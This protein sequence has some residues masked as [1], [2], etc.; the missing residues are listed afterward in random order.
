MI[1]G[2][3]M[4]M[5]GLPKVPSAERIDL[6]ANGKVVGL[7][8]TGVGR[9]RRP[10]CLRHHGAMP[11]P[12]TLDDLR[13][14]A[15]A[16]TLFTPTTL[17]ARDRAARLRAGR[18]DP[19]A[20][21]R[22]GPD[23]AP[24]R[25]GLPRRRPRA[26]LSRGSPIEEDFFV[27]YGFLPRAHLALMHPRTPRAAWTPATRAPGRATV[28]EFVRERGPAHPREVDAHFAHG[29]RH[30]LTGAARR[31]ATT[32]LL[33][34]M[35]Y[36]G[37]LRV[38]RRDGGTRIYAPPR[39][40]RRRRA[41][42]RAPQRARRAGRRSSCAS[43]R[44][45]RR[46]AWRYLVRLLRLRRAASAPQTQAALR[47]ARERARAARDRR[48]RP[49]T[50][51]PTRTRARAPCARRARCACSRRSIRSSGTGGASSCS[52]AGPIASRPTRRRRSASSATTRCRCCGATSVDRLGQPVRSATARCSAE[53]GY[54]AGRPPR[55]AAFA[56]ALDDE[57][58]AHARL[59]R[60]RRRAA[61]DPP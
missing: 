34:G 37:L 33:D 8:W 17:G 41:R 60:R 48:R 19:R 54:A 28:L 56:R 1:C 30:E 21:A 40:R 49:G 46:R 18:S 15:V 13:R 29:Q 3:I 16:R 11:P 5:P 45:C 39:T 26:P 20:G 61:A 53:I 44:R 52:G 57:L 22:A 9:R 10:G 4:T 51:R 14:Y 32:H 2:D 55:D 23:P 43:T 59:P 35:H 24:P 12:I 42:R 50:G 27:N 31:N 6:D 36:R 47:A 58:R 38:A 25:Q 7:F